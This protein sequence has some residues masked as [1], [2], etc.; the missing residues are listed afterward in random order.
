MKIPDK[1]NTGTK[2]A[3]LELNL[4][5]ELELNWTEIELHYSYITSELDLH[6]QNAYIVYGSNKLQ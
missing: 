1:I 2:P 4:D 6:T 3:E 5:I